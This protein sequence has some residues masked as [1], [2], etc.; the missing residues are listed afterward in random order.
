MLQGDAIDSTF[1]A[2]IELGRECGLGLEA[3]TS[4]LGSGDLRPGNFVHSQDVQ[5]ANGSPQLATFLHGW[6]AP[7]AEDDVEVASFDLVQDRSFDQ[8]RPMLT[9]HTPPTQI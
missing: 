6:L 5:H 8:H 3:C 9:H 7:F 4:G 2:A 1:V